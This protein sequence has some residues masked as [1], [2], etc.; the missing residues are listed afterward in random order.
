MVFKRVFREEK[1]PRYFSYK[2]EPF[3]ERAQASEGEIRGVLEVLASGSRIFAEENR[4][5]PFDVPEGGVVD[6]L[7]QQ[8]DPLGV[9]LPKGR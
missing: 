3:S 4:D 1:I 2:K 7:D 8:D 6:G 9:L 5:R